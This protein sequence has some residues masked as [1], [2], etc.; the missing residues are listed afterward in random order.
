MR[1]FAAALLWLL[2]T[3]LLAAAL[4]LPGFKVNLIDRQG[5]SA[6][7]QRAAGDADL[8]SATAAELAVQIERLGYDVDPAAVSRI[9]RAYTA[10]SKFPGQFAQ[11]N[12][13]ATGGC[14]PTAAQEWIH[15]ADGSS[16]SPRCSMTSRLPKHCANTTSRFLPRFRSR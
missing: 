9:A 13:F 2:T 14:S 12:G 16:T 8:Q 6:L 11:A 15:R 5:Y 1:A 7:A 4:P 3:I 10:S